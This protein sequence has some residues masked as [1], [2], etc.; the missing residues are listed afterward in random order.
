MN[1]IS[2]GSC[3]AGGR[4]AVVRRD[5]D[6]TVHEVLPAGWNVPTGVHGG[7]LLAA[8]LRAAESTLDATGGDLD[9]ML[10]A[11]GEDRQQVLDMGPRIGLGVVLF[12][13]HLARPAV[14][15]AGP[16]LVGPAEHERK[17][18][19]ARGQHRVQRTIE[20]TAAGKPV[21]VVAEAV[22]PG[23][24]RHLFVIADGRA[25]ARADARE[26]GGVHDGPALDGDDLAGMVL[27]P[28]DAALG[29]GLREHLRSP[30]NAGE[31]EAPDGRGRGEN[32]ACGDVLEFTLRVED[33]R[34]A[35]LR[36]RASACSAV[37]A[38]TKN[39]TPAAAGT[40]EPRRSTA[41]TKKSWVSNSRPIPSSPRWVCM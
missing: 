21:V 24:A 40:F 18:G 15:G 20:Q 4:E 41:S 34:V 37:I 38:A 5:P 28:F 10:L 23:G 12:D 31:L 2:D 16:V 19:L 27:G 22:D 33:G 7:M 25:H 11:I 6:G 3:G 29:P 14:P 17:V 36:F 30:R 1:S 9:P 35:E 32:P 39:A 13:Q 26:G 8:A